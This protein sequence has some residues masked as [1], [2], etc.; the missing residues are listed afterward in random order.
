MGFYEIGM[1]WDNSQKLN[2]DV[3]VLYIWIDQ[4]INYNIVFDRG[5]L[6]VGF[7]GFVFG[8]FNDENFLVELL[9]L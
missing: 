1:R 7:I 4:F 9:D 2:L 6:L 3:N 8:Y 5:R